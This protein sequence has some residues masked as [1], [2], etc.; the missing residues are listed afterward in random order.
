[1]FSLPHLPSKLEDNHKIVF[2]I[3]LKEILYPEDFFWGDRLKISQFCYWAVAQFQTQVQ[4]LITWKTKHWETSI[5]DKESLIYSGRQ[6][7]RKMVD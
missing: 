3:I 5:G 7:P 4:P 6:Q 2:Q 1:M